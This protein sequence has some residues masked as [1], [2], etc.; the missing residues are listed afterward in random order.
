MGRSEVIVY[1]C[2]VLTLTSVSTVIC[3]VALWLV[4]CVLR[5][6]IVKELSSLYRHVQLYYVMGRLKK[7]GRAQ[8]LK[9]FSD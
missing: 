3:I 8:T 4:V 7:V 1:W 6:E 9:E 2:G 5:R